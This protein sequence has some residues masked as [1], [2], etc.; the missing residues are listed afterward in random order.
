MAKKFNKAKKQINVAD[1]HLKED[2]IFFKSSVLFLLLCAAV[3]FTL[4]V[5]GMS[6]TFYM[7]TASF[8]PYAYGNVQLLFIFG[9]LT[10]AA[11]VY[12]VV[13]RKN[14]KDESMSYFSSTN[15]LCLAAFC[16]AYC[17]TY[18]IDGSS[19]KLLVLTFVCGVLYYINKFYN[20]DVV[21]YYLFNV[22][23]CYNLWS[24]FGTAASSR[25]A[26]GI[27]LKAFGVI[28]IVAV[29][30]FAYKA[31]AKAEKSQFIVWPFAMTAVI[32]VALAVLCGISTIT[33]TLA[34]VVMLVQFIAAGVYYTIKLLKY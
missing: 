7:M 1:K 6:K 28:G 13:C 3:L 21:W 14:K 26:L 27:V 30:Y 20:S 31:K 8:L 15:M 4:R 18:H 23:L 24:F 16:E 19:V 9:V 29:C 12:Y 25:P 32:F 22:L 34:M 33:T 5:D 17:F 11:A 2:I 10:V